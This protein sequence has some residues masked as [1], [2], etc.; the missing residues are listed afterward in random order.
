[1]KELVFS[2]FSPIFVMFSFI[3][4]SSFMKCADIKFLI[5]DRQRITAAFIITIWL[6]SP[7][8][9][10]HLVSQ[11]SCRKI[12]GMY[13]M[14]SDPDIVCWEG[15]H[16]DFVIG[17]V[18]PGI[19]VYIVIFPMLFLW[20]NYKNRQNFKDFKTIENYGKMQQYRLE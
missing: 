6:L 2:V 18:I 11:L 17:C 15:I 12:N 13:M 10:H 16:L 1:M 14:L 9:F 20:L 19:V 3:F 4:F 7:E 8:I 5:F